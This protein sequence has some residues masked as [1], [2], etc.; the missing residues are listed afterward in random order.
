VA[1]EVRDL[2]F[3]LWRLLPFGKDLCILI[4]GVDSM[5]YL[6]DCRRDPLAFE[7]V[8]SHSKSSLMVYHYSQAM[9]YTIPF[10][11]KKKKK[12]KKKNCLYKGELS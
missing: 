12:K 10:F 8:C 3:S 9:N 5:R 11:K 4:V 6:G 7:E 1:I 2:M